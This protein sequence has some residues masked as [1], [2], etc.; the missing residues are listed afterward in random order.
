MSAAV[1][2]Y[3]LRR[4]YPTKAGTAGRTALAGVD[5][6]VREGEVH[7]L[8]GPNGA[9]KTTLVRILATVLTPTSGRALVLGRDV[10][11][12]TRRVR[13]EVGVVFGGERGLYTRL[14][15][16][17]NLEFWAAMYHVRRRDAR[18][19]CA[20]LLERVGLD[21]RADEPVERLSRGMKQ[22]L[23][24]ARGMV[25]DP[26]V[27]FLDEPTSGMDPVAARAF[28]RLITGLR[29]E[30]RTV[31][32]T[33]HDMAEAEAVC[34][35]VSVIDHGSLVLSGR[36]A[37]IG[38]RLR[39][40]DTV[41]FRPPPGAPDLLTELRG[42]PGVHEVTGPTPAGEWCVVPRD[43]AALADVLTWLVQH[44][45]TSLRTCRPSLEEVYL[46]TIAGGTDSEKA[47]DEVAR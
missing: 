1:E 4:E 42:R 15:A 17:Q 18:V 27:L 6:T 11:E 43:E 19:R 8:L 34:D 28:R 22:R 41:E 26:R 35:Q 45:V 14:S 12:H 9:G 44:Q 37:L 32:L 36:P 47:A 5:L 2:T 46:R 21:D 25:H 10:T 30:G 20:T 31:L 39:T 13:A 33:T 24:L 38:R 7:G 16:R 29:A 3:H 40:V 23:H